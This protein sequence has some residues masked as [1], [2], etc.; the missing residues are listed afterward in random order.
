MIAEKI[1]ENLELIMNVER[2]YLEHL[3]N[4]E[5][6]NKK[7]M[8]QE[9]FH[10]NP[11]NVYHLRSVYY[12]YLK[13]LG[14]K[15][16]QAWTRF[17]K[18]YEKDPTLLDQ[19][20][21]QIE[22]GKIEEK[23]ENIKKEIETEEVPEE[24]SEEPENKGGETEMASKKDDKEPDKKLLEELA[25]DLNSTTGYVE[26]NNDGISTYEP[27]YAPP[28]TEKS[29]AVQEPVPEEKDERKANKLGFWLLVI[30]AITIPLIVALFISRQDKPSK[31]VERR[32]K[33]EEYIEKYNN[34]LN[35]LEYL[36]KSG[37]LP[38]F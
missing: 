20:A 18:D 29:E 14:Y 24:V 12:P 25:E 31:Q 9:E 7:L 11:T 35:N 38:E 1:K 37:K 4:K 33:D 30:G 23:Y 34:D 2:R 19:L 27:L 3:R 13:A 10:M 6:V 17:Y 36:L 32:S 16:K 21:E 22:K 15:S 28:T 8:I 5:H 26:E